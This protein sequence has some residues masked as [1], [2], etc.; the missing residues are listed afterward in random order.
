MKERIMADESVEQYRE[1]LML[2]SQMGDWIRHL[3][4]LDDAA[5]EG[6]IWRVR[7][8]GLLVKTHIDLARQRIDHVTA[9][10]PVQEVDREA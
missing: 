10:T 9:R 8:C 5:E 3:E 4:D 1:L 6:D 7:Y 2:L